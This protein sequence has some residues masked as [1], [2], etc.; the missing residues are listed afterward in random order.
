[1]KH[2]F[3]SSRASVTGLVGDCGLLA[4]PAGRAVGAFSAGRDSPVNVAWFTCRCL[5]A[6]TRPSAG[7]RSPALRLTMSPGTSSSMSMDSCARAPAS[8]RDTTACVWT[9][10][11]SASAARDDR[12]SCQNA[13]LLLTSAMV[14][15]TSAPAKSSVTSDTVARPSS[16]NTNGLLKAFS[17][18]Q[19][20]DRCWSACSVA[21]RPK[22]CSRRAASVLG[23]PW[24][25]L[26]TAEN[27]SS[28][29]AWEAS[30]A[31]IDARSAAVAL[32]PIP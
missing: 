18:C 16:T 19:Y 9:R 6:T 24:E 5:E 12:Y 21:L 14:P 17:S 30:K 32:R 4:G 2:I 11:R 26:S 7:T 3:C 20:Q 28:I 29:V 13:R 22:H 23:R 27:T 25:L 15:S 1:M 31:S 8:I 10:L